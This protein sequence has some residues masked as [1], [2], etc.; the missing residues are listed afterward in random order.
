M[1]VQ[2]SCLKSKTLK[3]TLRRAR[4]GASRR[5]ILTF[6]RGFAVLPLLSALRP[7]LLLTSHHEQQNK[8]GAIKKKK[9]KR[10]SWWMCCQFSLHSEGF[11]YYHYYYYYF[12]LKRHD[13]SVT[14][15]LCA[16]TGLI[17]LMHTVHG[18]RT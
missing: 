1:H 15:W 7:H 5:L 12:L 2:Y 17:H 14:R 4:E 13:L 18:S 3:E 16:H 6:A 11:F 8:P 9:K 10:K